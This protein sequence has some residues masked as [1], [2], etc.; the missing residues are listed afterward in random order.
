MC[1]YRVNELHVDSILYNTK[2]Y[3]AS[4]YA[5]QFKSYTVYEDGMYH[6]TYYIVLKKPGRYI[7]NMVDVYHNH[8]ASGHGELNNK[9]HE[10]QFEGKCPTLPFRMCNIIQGD[11]HLEDYEEEMVFLASIPII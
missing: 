7:M 9:V 5:D 1:P 6:Y 4:R 10:I 3:Y 2:Y 8:A 11:T